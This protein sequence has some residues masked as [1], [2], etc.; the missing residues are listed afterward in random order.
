MKDAASTELGAIC[1]SPGYKDFAPRELVGERLVGQNAELTAT[2][3][4][5]AD[6]AKSSLK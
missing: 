2:T 6:S 3:D 1:G 4:I 5:I